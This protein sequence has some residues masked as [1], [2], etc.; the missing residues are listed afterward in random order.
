[1]QNGRS[2]GNSGICRCFPCPA[3]YH[4]TPRVRF[5]RSIKHG[6]LE[7]ISYLQLESA[8]FH[9]LSYFMRSVHFLQ[10][11]FYGNTHFIIPQNL[12]VVHCA[13]QMRTKSLLPFVGTL[14][15]LHMGL[16]HVPSSDTPF[17]RPK[18]PLQAQ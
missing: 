14:P 1:M 2:E 15:H 7:Q 3:A 6:F 5:V 17:H 11:I 16:P 8:Y 9:L 12:P 13:R 4:R 10:S 18:A